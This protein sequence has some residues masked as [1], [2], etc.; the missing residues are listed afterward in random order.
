[1]QVVV[2]NGL[3]QVTASNPQGQ[4]TAVRYLGERSNLLNFVVGGENTGGYW[5]VVWNYPDSGH[6]R[7]MIDMYVRC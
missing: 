7:G 4:I 3:V 2:D 6:P 5:D 1:M